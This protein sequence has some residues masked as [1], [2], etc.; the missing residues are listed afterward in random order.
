[1]G[2]NDKYKELFVDTV[3]AN[4]ISQLGLNKLEDALNSFNEVIDESPDYAD[5]WYYLAIIYCNPYKPCFYMFFCPHIYWSS[6]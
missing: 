2:K 6:F 3:F 1:M 4:G 5:A